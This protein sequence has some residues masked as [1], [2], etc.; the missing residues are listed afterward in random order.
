MEMM[1]V[2][3]CSFWTLHLDFFFCQDKEEDDDEDDEDEDED[4]EEE[5]DEEEDDEE[6][7]EDMEEESEEE[8]EEEMKPTPRKPQVCAKWGAVTLIVFAF[9]AVLLN[10]E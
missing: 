4:D 9:L 5:D 1:W 10:T 2:G 7:D 3:I 8:E 6:D